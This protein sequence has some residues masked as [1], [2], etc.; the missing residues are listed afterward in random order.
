MANSSNNINILFV[1]MGNICRSPSAEAVMN[2]RIA[3]EGLSSKIKC[4]SA[5]TISF[6]AGEPADA[7][8]KQHAQKRNIRLTSISRQIR[9]EDFEEFD[10]VIGMDDENMFNMQ[11]FLPTPELGN[12]MSKM[13]DYC[14]NENPGHVPD[15]YYGGA[16]GFE[17]VL[18]ILEDACD[19]LLKHIRDEHKF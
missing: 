12:K 7:R 3:K 8:M 10:Y 9:S 2:S 18:D 11:S 1:C 14:S 4:D 17:Q 6:H 5:G 15:P 19:G 16:A 13:T